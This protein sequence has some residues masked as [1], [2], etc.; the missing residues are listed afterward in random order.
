[1]STNMLGGAPNQEMVLGQANNDF[2]YETETVHTTNP[3]GG[4]GGASS[5]LKNNLLRAPR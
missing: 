4:V 3:D 5:H 1:M 2:N